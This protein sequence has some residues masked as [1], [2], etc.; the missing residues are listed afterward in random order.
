[1]VMKNPLNNQNHSNADLIAKKV[2][3]LY[4]AQDNSVIEAKLVSNSVFEATLPMRSYK[5]KTVSDGSYIDTEQSID[6]LENSDETRPEN[7]IF[8]SP[9]MTSSGWRIVLQWGDRPK[10]LDLYVAGLSGEAIYHAKKVS[11]DQNIQ[12][13]WDVRRGKGP[14]TI[15]I[16]KAEGVYKVYVKNFS[17]EE[18]I[19]NSDANIQVYK[20]NKYVATVTV[21]YD[22]SKATKTNWYAFDLDSSLDKPVIKNILS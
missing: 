4:V 21:P 11:S 22:E 1:V 10:D 17:K 19:I 6:V 12:L 5:R 9:K 16:K 3:V 7:I 20:D 15:T 14:E 8:L 18:S 2:R 13:D